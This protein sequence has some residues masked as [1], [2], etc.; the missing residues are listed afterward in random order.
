VAGERWTAPLTALADAYHG[1]IPRLM[2]RAASA[3]AT[4]GESRPIHTTP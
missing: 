1:A 3:A 4:V 2:E